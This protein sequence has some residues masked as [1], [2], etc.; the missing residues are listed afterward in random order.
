M[1][2]TPLLAWGNF[3]ARSRFVRST[4]PEVK[5]GTTRSLPASYRRKEGVGFVPHYA[6]E[7]SFIIAKPTSLH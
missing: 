4:I 2:T 6:R 5:W 3:H 7:S 1:K